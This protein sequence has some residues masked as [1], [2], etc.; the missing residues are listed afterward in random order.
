MSEPDA[1]SRMLMLRTPE[2][3]GFIHLVD[4]RPWC[5]GVNHTTRCDPAHAVPTRAELERQ[6]AEVRSWNAAAYARARARGARP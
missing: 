5:D 3:E 2:L 6:A 4:G 1:L